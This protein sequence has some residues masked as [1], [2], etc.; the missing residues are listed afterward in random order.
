MVVRDWKGADMK[1]YKYR[2]LN[3]ILVR[4]CVY[5]YKEC[6][7]HKN[8]AYHNKEKQRNRIRKWYEKIKQYVM[9]NELIEVKIFAQ[10]NK[11]EYL[12]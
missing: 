11:F 10:K 7:D 3:K 2:T 1:Y 8:K 9:E 5:F 4:K 6:W 12:K